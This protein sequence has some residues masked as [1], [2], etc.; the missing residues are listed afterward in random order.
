MIL[1]WNL[2]YHDFILS[3]HNLS[4]IEIE[5]YAFLSHGILNWS[6]NQW[7][8]VVAWTRKRLKCIIQY[9]RCEI[10]ICLGTAFKK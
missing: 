7:I 10:E 5:K 6:I 1:N 9:Y 3:G 8:H 2:Y 4:I